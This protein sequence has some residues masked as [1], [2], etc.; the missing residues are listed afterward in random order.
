[1]ADPV[2]TSATRIWT[3]RAAYLGIGLGVYMLELVPLQTMPRDFA[4]PD[5]ILLMTFAFALRRPEFGPPALVALVIVLGDLLLL[6]P[7]GLM[8]GL[9][10]VTTEALRARADGLRTLPFTVEWLTAGLGLVGVLLGYRIV[11]AIFLIPQPPLLLSVSQLAMSILAYPIMV[12]AVAALFGV[13]RVA[14]GEVDT[15]GHKL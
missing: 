4:G 9:V 15:L 3:M 8:A 13:R 5:L 14:L 6:R 12:L 2:A 1:M 7:P 10:V 11:M